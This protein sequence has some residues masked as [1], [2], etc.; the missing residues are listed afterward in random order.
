V[1]AT[2]GRRSVVAMDTI[3]TIDVPGE[4]PGETANRD[5]AIER[6]LGW[7]AAV[8][9]CCTRFD[10]NSELMQLTAQCG[11]AVPVSDL[12]FEAIQ[13][14]VAVAHQ[15]GGAFDPAV[16]HSMHSRGFDREYTSGQSIRARLGAVGPVTYRDVQLNPDRK[17]VTLLRPLI[18]DLG[19]VAK[20]LAIDLAAHEL[21][22][23]PNFS[24]DAGG[25]LYLAGVN[26][27]GT[28]WS[29]GIRH[30]RIDGEL[31]DVLSISGRAVCTSGDYERR[32]PAE[33]NEHHILDPRSG[34]SPTNVASATV[35]APT[36]MLADALATAVFVL[37][38]LEGIHLLDDLG[39]DGLII[40]PALERHET[41]GMKEYRCGS[42]AIL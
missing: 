8:E 3:V 38:P 40:T 10:P 24:I 1:N 30:P 23:F 39:V 13:F 11:H 37:G 18:L 19:A 32:H 15:T 27:A 42:P 16:G 17:T 25:D 2:P 34:S 36:A 9:M 31:I 28:S 35:V 21:K 29:I 12:L 41:S 20:G 4:T 26:A 14:A 6:A 22:A 7:F 5:E 33:P